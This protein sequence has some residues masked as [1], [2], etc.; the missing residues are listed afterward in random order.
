LPDALIE[1]RLTA[2]TQAEAKTKAKLGD[3][4]PQQLSL[5]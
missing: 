1:A 2:K 3:R 4:T 5:I